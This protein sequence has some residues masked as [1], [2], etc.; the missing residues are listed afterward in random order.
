MINTTYGSSRSGLF[1]AVV[2]ALATGL[3]L[4]GPIGAQ[5]VSAQATPLTVLHNFDGTDGSAPVQGPIKASDGNFYGAVFDG[6]ISHNGTIYKLTPGGQ[7]TIL[8]TFQDQ[9]EGSSPKEII[10]GKDGNLYGITRG[11]GTDPITPAGGGTFFRLGLNGAFTKLYDFDNGNPNAGTFPSA[12]VQGSDGNF[13]GLT[14][15]GGSTGLGQGTYFRLSADGKT[16]TELRAFQ[17]GEGPGRS[18]EAQLIVGLDGN[19]YGVTNVGGTTG[20]DPGNGTIFKATKTGTITRIHLFQGSTAPRNNQYQLLQTSDGTLY[21]TSIAGGQHDFGTIY[22][23]T[24]SGTFTQLYEF[25]DPAIDGTRPGPLALGSDGNLYGVVTQGFPANAM[26]LDFGHGGFFQITPGGAFA[27]VCKTAPSGKGPAN[28]VGNLVKVSPNIFYGVTGAGGPSGDGTVV[29]LT[30]VPKLLNIATRLKVQTGDNILI[31]GFIITG[32][33]PKKVLIIGLGPSLGA[34]GVPDALPDPKLELHSGAT[35]VASND[36][37]RSA[38]EDEIQATG[39]APGDDLESGIIR[40]LNPG[41][42]TAVMTGKGSSTGIGV[43]EVF[44]LDRGANSTLANISTRGLVEAGDNILFAGIIVGTVNAKVIVEAL[45][46]STG[47]SGA[48]Q[49]PTLELHNGNGTTAATNDN[50]KINDQTGK[51]QEAEIRA[52]TVP[53]SNDLESAIL[54]TLAPGNYTAVVRGKNNS[55]GVA[56][57]EAFNLQ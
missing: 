31:A 47:V 2:G 17:S 1:R 11:G 40:T 42:Y 24:L 12:I 56:V 57:V 44:D 27:T 28:P 26:S 23:C 22:K 33:D 54:A 3:L 51:S 45:G 35:V 53:P 19:F 7:L 15:D 5:I 32:T 14:R 38:Q 37:W 18:P 13:Y 29:K 16:R 21:G 10:Q 52:T 48:L 39:V 49:D 34:A 41:A 20:G 4:L 8:H 36:N 9:L 50:W 43:V 30:V 6:G 55:T 46:P 25:E